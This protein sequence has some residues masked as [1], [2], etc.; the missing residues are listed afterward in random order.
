VFTFLF[1]SAIG[2]VAAGFVK[3]L[4]PLVSGHE[5]GLSLLEQRGYL[6]PLRAM[7]LV[8]SA[9]LLLIGACKDELEQASD[10]LF[11]WWITLPAALGCAFVQGVV[12]VVTLSSIG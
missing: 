6:L 4:W 8:M 3:N 2:L 10:G 1:V 5:V 12:V 7:A 9:P 11:S